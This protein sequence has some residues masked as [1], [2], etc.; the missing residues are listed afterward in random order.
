MKTGII[1]TAISV[2]LAFASTSAS[3]SYDLLVGEKKNTHVLKKNK[4]KKDKKKTERCWDPVTAIMQTLQCIADKD[5]VCASE[6]YAAG[7]QKIHNGI[8]TGLDFGDDPTSY[9]QGAFQLIELSFS[10]DLKTNIGPNTASIRYVEG[11]KF[12]DGSA[13]GLPA[14]DIYPFSAY[15]EQYEHAIVTVNGDCKMTKWDQYGDNT[16]QTDVDDAA[17]T[18]TK[19]LCDKNLFPPEVCASFGIKP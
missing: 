2:L 12:T 5:V 19:V 13:Y 18:M 3:A 4:N 8:D 9:W 14:S 1:Y 17:D 10:V 11:V 7:F 15:Y 6:G 16:E